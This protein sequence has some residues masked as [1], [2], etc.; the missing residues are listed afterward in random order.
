MEYIN[1]NII[2]VC[3]TRIDLLREKCLNHLQPNFN[4]LCGLPG[5]SSVGCD[6]N[7]IESSGSTLW[8][9]FSRQVE[10]C[11]IRKS[12]FVQQFVIVRSLPEKRRKIT[13]KKK[14]KWYLCFGIVAAQQPKET[15]C[16]RE[17]V[18]R[19]M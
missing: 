15:H 19:F 8:N 9:T 4:S 12:S 1:N 18:G 5:I 17:L 13:K 7:L 6:G 11:S 3:I 16:Q 14:K 2:I 10:F